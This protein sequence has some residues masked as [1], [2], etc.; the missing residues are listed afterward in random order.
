MDMLLR[1]KVLSFLLGICS[2]FNLGLVLYP[3]VVMGSKTTHGVLL[4]YALFGFLLFK[5]VVKVG[6]KNPD[7]GYKLFVRCIFAYWGVPVLIGYAV[8]FLFR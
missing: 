3:D 2:L 5:Y 8:V 1:A 7:R 4:G 6:E